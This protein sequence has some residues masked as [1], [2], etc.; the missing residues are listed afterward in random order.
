MK[1]ISLKERRKG[2]DIRS[3]ITNSKTESTLLE[4]KKNLDSTKKYL[5]KTTTTRIISLTSKS[6]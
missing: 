6:Y 3:K 1:I 4:N 5:M 2:F